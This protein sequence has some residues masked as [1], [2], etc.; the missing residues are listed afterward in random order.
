MK[1]FSFEVMP[2]S[3]RLKA[4]IVFE[5]DVS[6]RFGWL[7]KKTGISRNTWQTWWDKEDAVPSG[8]MVETVARL[9][10]QYAYWLATGS[11]DEEYGH[12]APKSVQNSST[13]PEYGGVR[14]ASS[15]EY[16]KHCIA[17]QNKIASDESYIGSKEWERD[18]EQL[19][20][21]SWDREIKIHS[22]RLIFSTYEERLRTRPAKVNPWMPDEG[23]GIHPDS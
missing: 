19:D 1:K 23:D 16:L 21:I 3:A 5:T 11:T 2:M 14:S 12:K 17:M 7:Q 10:P 20:S 8:K 6:G 18:W 22:M 15:S 13:W 9:W 4:V